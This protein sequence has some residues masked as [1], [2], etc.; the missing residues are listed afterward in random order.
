MEAR[1]GLKSTSAILAFLCGFV[2]SPASHAGSIKVAVASNFLSTAKLLKAEF[3]QQGS[4]DIQIISAS[5]GQLSHQ[6]LNGAPFDVFL[7]ANKQHPVSLKQQLNL[8]Q[9]ALFQYAQG[10]LVLITHQA[11]NKLPTISTDL[12]KVL[13]SSH[14]AD[15]VASELQHNIIE[16]VLLT[17]N[18]VAIANAKLAPYGQASEE[19]LSTLSLSQL[20]KRKTVKGQNI[21]QTFQFFTSGSADAAFV[22][23]SHWL[24]SKQDAKGVIHIDPKW[25]QPIEQW[26]LTIN[27][28]QTSQA[29]VQFL[30]QANAVRIIKASGYSPALSSL[31][32]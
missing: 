17:A 4:H 31:I 9:D 22:A 14:P 28:S 19:T 26:G 6:I 25:H 30:S 15:T 27:P 8:P 2:F 11:I 12:R 5:T 23:N 1:R 24:Q 10:S 32:P 20:I 29:F 7:S 21:A 13:S 16:Q 3:E 18:K